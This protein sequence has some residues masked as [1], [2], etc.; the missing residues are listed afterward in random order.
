MKDFPVE[1]PT[2][3]ET[4]IV[5]N[6]DLTIKAD[7]TNGTLFYDVDAKT[8][9][10]INDFSSV[11]MTLPNKFVRVAA[12]YQSDGSLV[13]VRIWASSTFNSVWLSPE[14]HILHVN[15]SNASA[16]IITVE[17]EL[18]HGVDVTVDANTKFF[19]RTP[20]KAV[21]DATP[22]GTGP[23]F[24]TAT[25]LVRGF[26]VHISVDDPF[27]ATW[28][29]QDVD[30]EI[31]QY[32]GTISAAS[33]NDFTYTRNFALSSDDYTKS[34]P[35]ISGNTP[36][37]KDSS[38]NQIL[39]F[40]WWNFTFPTL[41]NSGPTATLSFMTA[42]SGAVNFGNN[43]TLPAYGVSYATWGDPNALTGWAAPWTVLIPTPIPL[44][45]AATGYVNGSPNGTFTLSVPGGNM[46]APVN[47][48]TV[49]GSGTLVYQV[50]RTGLVVTVSAV[51]ITT[52]TGQNTITQN[53]TP[54]TPVKVYGVPQADGSIKAYVVTYFTGLKPVAV[55]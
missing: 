35:Y 28:V 46:S 19:Y 43:I 54:T 44:G 14:G 20:W 48:S 13:A 49:T 47:L 9:S 30:I 36:N 26:K 29:A 4:A 2:N 41:V 27:A 22:I 38:G 45:T 39:G 55:N 10:T 15:T 1:P 50:D 5:T 33:L 23:S 42:T 53:L 18:G 40:K 25:N 16:P 3:P 32:D 11:A 52:M 34:L 51:D 8:S 6:H 24:V 31:A 17:N 21:A 12:R 7:A 37:G